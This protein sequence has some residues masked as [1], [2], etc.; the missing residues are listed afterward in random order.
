MRRDLHHFYGSK[1]EDTFKAYANALTQ[2][3]FNRTPSLVEFKLIVVG[4]SMS[5]RFNMN[6]GSLHIHLREVEEGT[7]V[8]L[9]FSI[10]Q[11]LGARYKAYDSILTKKVE[12]Q[13]NVQSRDLKPNSKILELFSE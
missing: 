5:F 2:E 13:L 4:L 10:V 1:I 11:L 8:Q 12:K 7:V 3:P 6:G 9:R